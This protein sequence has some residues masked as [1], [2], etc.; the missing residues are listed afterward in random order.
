[1]QNDAGHPSGPRVTCRRT[2]RWTC[3]ACHYRLPPRPP[4]RWT[5]PV[6]RNRHKPA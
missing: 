6:C 1:M 4:S 5:R 3:M 2:P